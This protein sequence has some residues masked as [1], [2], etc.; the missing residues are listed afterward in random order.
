MTYLEEGGADRLD[1]LKK[2][3]LKITDQ[4]LKFNYIKI[5][6]AYCNEKFCLGSN[7]PKWIPF[8]YLFIFIKLK[9]IIVG[10]IT[11]N[12]ESLD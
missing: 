6:L 4:E 1:Y 11:V 3:D 10:N 8:T 7:L 12:L 9:K 2:A 5:K